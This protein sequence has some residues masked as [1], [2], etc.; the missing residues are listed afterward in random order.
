VGPVLLMR[1]QKNPCTEGAGFRYRVEKLGGSFVTKRRAYNVATWGR[2]VW[3]IKDSSAITALLGAS[4]PS[5]GS[6]A[7][8]SRSSRGL[9]CKT[10]LNSEL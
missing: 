5:F 1:T 10:A 7:Q 8:S 3:S 9:S 4:A 6:G 2:A